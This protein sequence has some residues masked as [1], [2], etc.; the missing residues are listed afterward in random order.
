MTHSR[1][2]S[3]RFLTRLL[4]SPVYRKTHGIDDIIHNIQNSLRTQIGQRQI[5]IALLHYVEDKNGK[6]RLAVT[7]LL[8]SNSNAPASCIQGELTS[9]TN[10]ALQMCAEYDLVLFG[11]VPVSFTTNLSGLHISAEHVSNLNWK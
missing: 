6:S 1:T 7:A 9:G 8:N 4:H 10:L 11:V 2:D 3:S 5:P